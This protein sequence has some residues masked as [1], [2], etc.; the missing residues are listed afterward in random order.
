MTQ[1]AGDVMDIDA[2]TVATDDGDG[3]V[4]APARA[5]ATAARAAA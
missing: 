3:G 5:A 2:A 4:A 1:T